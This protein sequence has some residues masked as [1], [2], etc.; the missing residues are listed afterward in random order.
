M[1]RSI[2]WQFRQKDSATWHGRVRLPDLTELSKLIT[3]KRDRETNMANKK[4]PQTDSGASAPREM[5]SEQHQHFQD[6][7]DHTITNTV[8]A[9]HTG[10][11]LGDRGHTMPPSDMHKQQGNY[12]PQGALQ[13]R[14]NTSSDSGSADADDSTA[15]SDYGTLDRGK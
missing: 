13:N 9:G 12:I 7:V 10:H 5:S 3:S 6:L 11:A 15:A 14:Q 4:F 1:R 2:Q 8:R